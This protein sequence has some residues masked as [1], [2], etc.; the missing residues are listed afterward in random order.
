MDKSRRKH[1]ALDGNAG[2]T[3]TKASSYAEERP[4]Q[5]SSL[6]RG[7]EFEEE[8]PRTKRMLRTAEESKA[9]ATATLD[10]LH[11][12]GEQLDRAEAA[13]ER[14]EGDLNT[15]DWL[16]RGMRSYTGALVNYFVAPPPPPEPAVTESKRRPVQ[17]K[18]RSSSMNR[19]DIVIEED[20][21]WVLMASG[22]RVN[23]QPAAAMPK[24]EKP[25]PQ[26]EWEKRREE[27][28]D[29]D[30]VYDV[31]SNLKELSMEAGKEVR[32]QNEQLDR[33]NGGMDELNVK[34]TKTNKRVKKHLKGR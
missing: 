32:K 31:V 17:R 15:A 6:Y 25:T 21:E 23:R 9:V 3:P 12:Q 19:G 4:N 11:H 26:D 13:M 10:Q 1:Q 14:M 30:N 18:T 20:E 8:L 22:K 29:L 27:D 2:R 24:T 7:H 16:L 34:I 33:L 5:L 28:K